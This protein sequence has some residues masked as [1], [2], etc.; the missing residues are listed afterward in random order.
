MI[1]RYILYYLVFAKLELEL[2]KKIY[3][4]FFIILFE[5]KHK[6]LN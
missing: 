1:P 3:A 4:T 2:K 6:K 5:L